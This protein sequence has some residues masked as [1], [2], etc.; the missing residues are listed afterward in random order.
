[1]IATKMSVAVTG[2]MLWCE[3]Q[4]IKLK[5]KWLPSA[6]QCTGANEESSTCGNA[7]SETCAARTG[8]GVVCTADCQTGCFCI[9]GYARNT[10]GNC[11]PISQCPS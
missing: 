9:R 7:C 8:S 3:Y 6:T 1:M 2:K 4:H 11:V 5:C 10:A